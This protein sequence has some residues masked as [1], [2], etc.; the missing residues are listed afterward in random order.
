MP[1]PPRFLLNRSKS[2]TEVQLVHR[3]P[4]AKCLSFETPNSSADVLPTGWA[5]FLGGFLR[6]E[7]PV[8]HSDIDDPDSSG[9]E[10]I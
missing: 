3:G 7:T 6:A 4:R 8:A 5:A 1:N 10:A 9:R 2:P